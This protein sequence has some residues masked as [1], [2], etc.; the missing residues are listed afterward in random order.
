MVTNGGMGMLDIP[1]PP[2]DIFV[3]DSDDFALYTICK[4]Q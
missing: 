3:I 1:A 2:D 4:M